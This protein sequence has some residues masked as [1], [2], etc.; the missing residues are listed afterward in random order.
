MFQK[1][2]INWIMNPIAKVYGNMS[3]RVRDGIFVAAITL[4]MLYNIFKVAVFSNVPYIYVFAFGNICFGVAILAM[5]R[6][7]M[8]PVR[9]RWFPFLFWVAAAGIITVTAILYNV[10][11]ISDAFVMLVMCPVAFL[12]WQQV[13]FERIMRLLSRAAL[14]S[15]GVYVLL[16]ALLVP[17]RSQQY[18]GLFG[19]VNGAA[20]YLVVVFVCLLVEALHKHKNKWVD[21]AY[22]IVFGMCGALVF[23]TNSRTGQLAALVAFISILGLYALRDWKV[24][25]KRIAKQAVCMVLAIVVMFPCTIY[26]FHGLR[27]VGSLVYTPPSQGETETDIGEEEIGIGGFLEYNSAKNEIGAKNVDEIST[28]RVSIWK[29]YLTHSTWFGSGEKEEFFVASR[30]ADYSTAHMTWITYAFRHGYVCAI[31]FLIYCLLAGAIAIRFAYKRKGNLWALLPL[32]ISIVFGITS[33]L[34]SINTPFSYMLTMYY[35]FVQTFLITKLV[36]KEPN[37]HEEIVSEN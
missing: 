8:Q 4:L 26:M 12:V 23:C 25:G 24:Q 13:G 34:A 5:M 33:L 3:E 37:E 11:W 29:E 9:V 16:S 2:L 21:W 18:A 36:T 27:R 17:M 14:I 28:G 32:A 19:N 15:F 1:Y 22:Y 7:N 31:L 35:Y 10:D 20:Q 6:P 30:N